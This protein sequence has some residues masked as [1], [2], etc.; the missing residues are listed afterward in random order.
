MHF[1]RVE[2]VWLQRLFGLFC[3]LKWWNQCRHQPLI[4]LA[5][6]VFRPMKLRAQVVHSRVSVSRVKR[7]LACWLKAIFQSE[8]NAVSYWISNEGVQAFDLQQLKRYHSVVQGKPAAYTTFHFRLLHKRNLFKQ[9]VLYMCWSM[10]IFFCLFLSEPWK[11]RTE[12]PNQPASCFLQLIFGQTRPIGKHFLNLASF[13][14]KNMFIGLSSYMCFMH[15]QWAPQQKCFWSEQ[16]LFISPFVFQS[17]IPPFL[18]SQHQ[19]LVVLLYKVSMETKRPITYHTNLS[20]QKAS[21]IKGS[22]Q[23]SPMD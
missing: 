7:L 14:K 17:V 4:F 16:T 10:M 6:F 11:F 19:F 8:L 21:C 2:G 15:N 23:A 18:F 13:V 9:M 3:L 12:L 5:G 22:R 1:C 20:C